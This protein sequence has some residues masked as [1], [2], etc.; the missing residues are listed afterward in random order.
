MGEQKEKK[1]QATS[2]RRQVCPVRSAVRHEPGLWDH[3]RRLWQEVD[4]SYRDCVTS[5]LVA[6]ATLL[7][8]FIVLP[9]SGGQANANLQEACRSGAI[10]DAKY[11]ALLC[12]EP[13]PWAS[14]R[15]LLGQLF[16]AF[17]LGGGV[18]VYRQ[19]NRRP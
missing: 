12:Q 3:V 10:T 2:Q 11:K 17:L 4:P 6:L 15:Q 7:V 18:F 8:L 16:L 5:A 9:P 1:A 13:S 19:F 14:F